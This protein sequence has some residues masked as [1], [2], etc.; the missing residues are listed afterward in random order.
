[1]TQSVSKV[2]AF[3][4]ENKVW[5]FHPSREKTRRACV[6]VLS[7]L[8]ETVRAFIMESQRVLLI[9]PGVG[10][11]GQVNP[12]H[13]TLELGET[14]PRFQVIVL[15]ESLEKASSKVLIG[16]VARCVAAAFQA[17]LNGK[18]LKVSPEETAVSWG[19]PE[20]KET[21]KKGHDRKFVN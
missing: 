4:R 19:F 18:V 11:V 17:S 20:V 8:P 13:V 1:M 12:Y 16:F 14:E 9:A 21:S 7:R 5:C 2:V 6:E 3:I 10:F 15:C